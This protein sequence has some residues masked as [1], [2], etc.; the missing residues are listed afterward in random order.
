MKQGEIILNLWYVYSEDD[1]FV[2]SLRAKPYVHS[3]S[4]EEKFTFL[5]SR[6]TL[7]YLVACVDPIP[8]EFITHFNCPESSVKMPVIHSSYFN[9]CSNRLSIFE[10]LLKKIENDLPAQ[11]RLSIPENPV[12]CITPLRAN[13]DGD[14]LPM[15]SNPIKI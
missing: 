3:G 6:A 14:L 4:E 12:V 10:Q 1:G 5:R 7:D 9:T 11:T 13:D 2:Y 15:T 8:E